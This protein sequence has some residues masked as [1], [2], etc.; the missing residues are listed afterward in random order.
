MERRQ[1]EKD[2]V[3]CGFQRS[4]KKNINHPVPEVMIDSG[5]AVTI[6][7]DEC[8]FDKIMDLKSKIVMK[9]NGGNT[10]VERE[11]N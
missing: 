10:D 4:I 11:G 1:K 2:C 9:T 6:A 7:K 3:F 5:S 8:L